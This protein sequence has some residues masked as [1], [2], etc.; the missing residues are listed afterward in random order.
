MTHGSHADGMI[1]WLRTIDR[2]SWASEQVAA[3][4]QGED[5]LLASAKFGG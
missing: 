3:W 5:S 4:A 1:G 2:Y